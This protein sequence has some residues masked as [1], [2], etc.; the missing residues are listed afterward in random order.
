VSSAPDIAV[1]AVAHCS[2]N[3]SVI[4][5]ATIPTEPKYGSVHGSNRAAGSLIQAEKNVN[6]KNIYSMWLLFFTEYL[7]SSCWST[8]YNTK[9]MS[10]QVDVSLIS[11]V[12]YVVAAV[13][14]LT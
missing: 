13:A 7:T 5:T 12:C 14:W 10:R 9:Q 11:H 4:T 3:A 6:D 2:D 8:Y 1:D